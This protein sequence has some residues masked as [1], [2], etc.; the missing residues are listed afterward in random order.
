MSSKKKLPS[1]SILDF[2]VYYDSWS[3][4]ITTA[5]IVRMSAAYVQKSHGCPQVISPCEVYTEAVIPSTLNTSYI[6][7][8]DMCEVCTEAVHSVAL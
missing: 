3:L 1:C 4:Y 5:T 2:R 8:L 7:A 6:T